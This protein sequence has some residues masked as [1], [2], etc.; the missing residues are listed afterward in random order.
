[1]RRRN[2]PSPP[3]RLRWPRWETYQH[4]P[5]GWIYPASTGPKWYDPTQEPALPTEL[6]RIVRAYGRARS[7]VVRTRKKAAKNA[8]PTD[9]DAV[10]NA[11]VHFLQQFGFLGQTMLQERAGVRLAEIEGRRQLATGDHFLWVLKHASHVASCL[12]LAGALSPGEHS[13]RPARALRALQFIEKIRPRLFGALPLQ[14]PTLGR[15]SQTI[16]LSTLYK[17]DDTETIKARA[18]LRAYL[19]PNL[20]GVERGYDPETGQSVLKFTA[21]IQLIYW[22]V[23][24]WIDG[25]RL[26]RCE[27]CQT[28]FF[29]RDDRQRFCPRPLALGPGESLCAKRFHMRALR[30]TD[31]T[32]R[33]SEATM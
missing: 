32:Q 14:I 13:N 21:L 31:T 4:A 16:D 29:A 20:R 7:S 22:Q 23:A 5:D 3:Y 30:N 28:S 12:E 11:I 8:I 9:A 10:K 15:A 18:L 33:D 25:E 2:A 19:E 24:D 27:E 6:T 26:R 1:M 17:P